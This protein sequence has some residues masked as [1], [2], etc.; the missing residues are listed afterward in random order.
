MNSSLTAPFLIRGAW[1]TAAQ[2]LS[3]GLAPSGSTRKPR[4][5]PI[6]EDEWSTLASHLISS[7]RSQPFLFKQLMSRDALA[8][9]S[10]HELSCVVIADVGTT[11]RC[12]PG[13]TMQSMLWPIVGSP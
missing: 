7:L 6:P 8:G 10:S 12:R 1:Y 9:S 11:V 5:K 2:P 3:G 13:R 4:L